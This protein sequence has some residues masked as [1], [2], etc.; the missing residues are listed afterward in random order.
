MQEH[1]PTVSVGI[2][3]MISELIRR[4]WFIAAWA[5]GA[6]A[7]MSITAILIPSKFTATATLLAP[8]SNTP[9]LGAIKG[10]SGIGDLLGMNLGGSESPEYLLTTLLS[11][12]SLALA[13]RAR[14]G[15]D[16][17]WKIDDWTPEDIQKKWE[18]CFSFRFDDNSALEVN[19][20]DKSPE[21]ARKV[22]LSVMEWSDSAFRSVNQ[23]QANRNLA[24]FDERLK[25]RKQWLS[26][27][28]DSLIEF[29]RKTGTFLPTE[30]IKQS[31]I[32]ASKMEA[33]IENVGIQADLER[34]MNGKNSS[35]AAQLEALRAEL[36]TRLSRL[37]SNERTNG[38]LLK[39]F[40]PAL[41]DQ[42]QFERL[43]RQVLI[44]GTVYAFL[45][46][47][48]EQFA[49]ERARNTRLLIAIDPPSTPTK[50]SFPKRR[51]LVEAAVMFALLVSSCWVLFT[52]WMREAVE[53][54]FAQAL[55]ELCE[56][57]RKLR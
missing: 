16:T 50:R 47:Q 34:Q 54:P 21:F 51:L 41:R 6:G 44:H 11:S 43:N 19:F 9:G 5:L 40:G 37:S 29:Q 15:L 57:L 33:Q 18:R 12:R 2:I 1:P 23:E 35:S 49:L 25:E 28:E 46:Q 30:Q 36:K 7:V 26:T 53:D 39:E 24:F 55:R 17:V 14:F 32:E 38:R 42:L 20:E 48:R 52:W 3:R 13:Q 45:N 56:S 10:L 27:A 22:L 4:K 31:I 8:A